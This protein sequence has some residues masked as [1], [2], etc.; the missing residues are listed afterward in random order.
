[1]LDIEKNISNTTLA[2]GRQPTL[3]IDLVSIAA[4][5]MLEIVASSIIF[6]EVTLTLFF[7]WHLA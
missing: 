6:F 4:P 2:V 1:M 3:L 5:N 7:M